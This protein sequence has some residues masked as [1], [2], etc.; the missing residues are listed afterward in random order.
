MFPLKSMGRKFEMK[1]LGCKVALKSIEVFSL[2]SKG[3][4][5]A[6]FFFFSIG[7][8]L[9]TLLAADISAHP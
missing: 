9:I 4:D 8:V 6:S 3:R 7:K 2:K 1:S 5:F